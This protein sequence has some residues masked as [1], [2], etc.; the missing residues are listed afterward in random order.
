M[1][2]PFIKAGDV[3]GLDTN[4]LNYMDRAKGTAK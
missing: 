1:V 3:M 4:N 2:P